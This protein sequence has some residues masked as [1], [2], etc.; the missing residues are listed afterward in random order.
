MNG[1]LNPAGAA[2]VIKAEARMAA[3]DGANQFAGVER[4]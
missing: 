1:R 3:R 4:D 2:A